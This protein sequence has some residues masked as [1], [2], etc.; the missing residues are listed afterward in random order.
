MRSDELEAMEID[1]IADL[2]RA[3]RDREAREDLRFG[4]L[5][6]SIVN[7]IPFRGGDPIH[8]SAIFPTIPSPAKSPRDLRDKVSRFARSLGIDIEG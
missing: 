3:W 7:S 8:P 4:V 1:E 5:A 6:A 2:V